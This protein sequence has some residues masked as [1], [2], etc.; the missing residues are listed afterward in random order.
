MNRL[1]SQKIESI[2]LLFVSAWALSGACVEFYNIAWGTGNWLGQFSPKWFLLFLFFVLFCTAC[3]GGVLF[4]LW[5]PEKPASVFTSASSLRDKLKGIRWLLII[6]ILGM[7]V[8]FFQYTPWGRIFGGSNFRALVWALSVILISW[9]LSNGSDEKFSWKK[10]LV[11]LILTAGVYSF[12]AQL[13]NI[14]D[15]PFSIGWSEGNRLW[16]YSILFGHAIYKFPANKPIPVF[17]DFGRQLLGGIPFL[18]PG[19]TI[20]QERLWLGLIDV[21]P[22]L[23]L[24]WFAFR[25]PRKNFSY[26]IL[27]GIWGFTFVEQG[28]IHPPLLLSAILVTIAWKQSLWL[29]IPVILGASYF[30]EVSRTTWLFAPGMWAVMLEFAGAALQDGHLTIKTWGRTISVGLS[31]IVGGL[32]GPKVLPVMFNWIGMLFGHPGNVNTAGGI[33]LTAIQTSVSDQPLLWYRLLPNTTYGYGI[34]FGLFL[35][36]APLVVVL[37]YLSKTGSWVLNAWQKLGIILPLLAFFIVGLIVSVKI[38]GGGDLHNMDMFI[39]GLM[40]VGAIA[41][42]S[43]DRDWIEK[44]KIFSPWLQI[45]LLLLVIMPAYRPYMQLNPS[46]INKNDISWV[47]TLADIP[48]TDSALSSFPSETYISDALNS[49]RSEAAQASKQGDVLFM[50]QR[51]LLT[52]GYINDVSLIPEY[53]KKVLIDRAL[54]G[55]ALYFQTYY[56]DLASQRFSLIISN[57]LHENIQTSSDD[58]GEENNAWVKWVSTPTLCY[59]ETLRLIKKVGVELLVPRSDTSNCSQVLP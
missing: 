45:M 33:T 39:I 34:L 14:T 42:R 40:F 36:T 23:I 48:P 20:W 27:A 12:F 16:D 8:Y 58:F 46:V 6:I 57:P 5:F 59:Y 11:A 22:Y 10:I 25:F 13:E 43:S 38:G 37:L 44:D 29:A 18:I 50:D 4:S 1:S 9:L 7:P 55:D 51:Q 30:A 15:Y 49:I 35:A 2:L 21:I 53:D 24:G 31:G 32:L 56:K 54:S 47:M 52:F 41:W 28:P 26:W 17:L 3:L 19:I